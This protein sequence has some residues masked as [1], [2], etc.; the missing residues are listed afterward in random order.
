MAGEE[1]CGLAIFV[2]VFT[3]IHMYVFICM[4]SCLCIQYMGS[5]LKTIHKKRNNGMNRDLKG[6]IDTV[7]IRNMPQ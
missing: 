2:Y 5:I 1:P 4:Y 6:S 7:L 3:C